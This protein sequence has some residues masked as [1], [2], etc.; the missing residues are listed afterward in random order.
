MKREQPHRE[1]E[2]GCPRQRNNL[3]RDP[4]QKELRGFEEVKKNQC[5]WKLGAWGRGCRA[6][7][8]QGH[9][10]HCGALRKL[11]LTKGSKELSVGEYCGLQL[12]IYQAVLQQ[13]D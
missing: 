8:M 1:W 6:Q 12:T 13:I 10:G 11:F 9:E 2:E 3:Y 5:G 4:R 7:I